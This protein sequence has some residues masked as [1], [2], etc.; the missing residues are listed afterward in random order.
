[1]APEASRHIELQRT[2]AQMSEYGL[3][4]LQYPDVVTIA[5]IYTAVLVHAIQITGT[6]CRTYG[7]FFSVIK[8]ATLNTYLA[9]IAEVLDRI[10]A[11][12]GR[13]QDSVTNHRHHE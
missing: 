10:I 8:E 3:N 7:Y 2:M 12:T 1:M 6:L 4:M 13:I 11:C 5:I 9:V